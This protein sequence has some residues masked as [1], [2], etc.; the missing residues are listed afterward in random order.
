[1]V[2][3]T[4]SLRSRSVPDP[5]NPYTRTEFDFNL[6]KS[7]QARLDTFHC[8]T[9]RWPLTFISPEDCAKAGFFFLKDGDK[10]QCAFC[11][12]VAG[13]WELG[14]V[15]MN[16]H[17]KHFPRCP[18]LC[19]LPVGNIPIGQTAPT[20]PAPQSAV[21][22]SYGF[23]VC[24]PFLPPGFA[25]ST[26]SAIRGAFPL[27][28][29]PIEDVAR[30]LA[31]NTGTGP[32]RRHLVTLQAR[33][34]TFKDW[35]TNS[36]QAPEKMADAG[37]FFIGTQ[38]HVKCFYCDGGLRNWEPGDDPWF[39]HARWF[40]KCPFVLLMKGHEYVREVGNMRPPVPDS[41]SDESASSSQ[42]PHT[43]SSSEPESGDEIERLA[44]KATASRTNSGSDSGLSD[45]NTSGE[46]AWSSDDEATSPVPT[47]ERKGKQEIVFFGF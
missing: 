5:A 25:N 46:Q 37:F 18:F 35:P 43:S 38:D 4:N 23:D 26:D 45:H 42:E 13:E 41:D 15:P 34:K 10:V 32:A 22:P 16:E 36:G 9:C 17:K 27:N 44:N 21:D 31:I 33:L 14:D 28:Q 29:E 47:A 19:N 1:M 6:L 40:S 2:V 30:N 20:I 12:G 39:E 24:G 11:R 7:E 8:S 3:N